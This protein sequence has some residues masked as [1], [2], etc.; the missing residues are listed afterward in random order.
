ML[1]HTTWTRAVSSLAV[2][3]ALIAAA[4]AYTSAQDILWEQAPTLNPAG[5]AINVVTPAGDPQETF[6]TALVNDLT[7]NTDVNVQE[8]TTYF[9]NVNVA[10]WS[11]GGTFNAVLNIFD[12]DPLTDA[13]DAFGGGDFGEALVQVTALDPN[14]SGFAGVWSLTVSGLDIDLAAGDYFFGLTPEYASDAGQEFHV[15]A[16]GGILGQNTSFRNPD[17]GI[18]IGAGWQDIA[19]LGQTDFDAAIT[20]RG[21]EIIPEPTSAGLLA[22]GLVGLVSRRRR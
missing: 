10:P 21:E 4:P 17:N 9:S 20:V 2:V 11:N 15:A 8:V 13:D 14:N 19:L 1:S 22:L 18:G 7:F 3:A 5:G 12:A 16:D 6:S